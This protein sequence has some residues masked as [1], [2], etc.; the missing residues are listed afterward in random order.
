MQICLNIAKS[1][2]SYRQKVNKSFTKGVKK[3]NPEMIFKL[4]PGRAV[5]Y[6]LKSN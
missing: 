1:Y 3:N 6:W 4:Q 5:E 2:M